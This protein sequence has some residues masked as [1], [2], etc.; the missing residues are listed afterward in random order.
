MTPPFYTIGHSTRDID[1]FA[2]ML[3]F[4]KVG[5]L[6]DVRHI[7]RSRFNP[8]Y[9]KD[10]LPGLLS[11]YGI[12]YVHMAALGGKRPAQKMDGPSPNSYWEN[13]SFRNYAD[14][15]MGSEFA[16]A[17]DHLRQIGLDRVCAIMCAEAVWWRCHRRII[18]D[19]LL[20]RGE[21]VFH[22]MG[23]GT[24]EPAK[25]TLGARPDGNNALIYPL[26]NNIPV[27]LPLF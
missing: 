19:H 18:V 25:L 9:N 4:A 22:I 15:A 16:K 10:V 2:D 7:P 6:V 3:R 24:L 12:D 8:Q 17:L 21:T 5:T 1:D 27:Q 14:Y 13:Q 11:E 23:Q 26:P 20:H